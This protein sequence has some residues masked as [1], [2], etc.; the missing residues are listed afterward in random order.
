MHI[1]QRGGV[2]PN[3]QLP[4]DQVGERQ[5]VDVA[6]GSKAL[7]KRA[8]VGQRPDFR[9]RV[10]VIQ[11]FRPDGIYQQEVRAGNVLMPTLSG[12]PS[13]GYSGTVGIGLSGLP[14]S[15]STSGVPTGREKLGASP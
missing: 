6:R 11:Y 4:P 13:A 12:S 7:L 8:I 14:A 2:D 3:L 1:E 15:S 9:Q 5:L 10:L